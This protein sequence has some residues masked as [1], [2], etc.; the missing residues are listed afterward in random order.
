[1]AAIAALVAAPPTELLAANA[2]AVLLDPLLAAVPDLRAQIA[3][4]DAI[5]GAI[6]ALP[7][8]GAVVGSL[9][10]LVTMWDL[11]PAT[12]RAQPI[13]D[14]LQ[15]LQ[16]LVDRLLAVVQQSQE[17]VQN[18]VTEATSQLARVREQ[19]VGGFQMSRIACFQPCTATTNGTLTRRVH[20]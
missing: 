4:M 10:L 18:V 2:A 8:R 14:V 16:G 11:L 3:L 15:A 1:M 7:P 19:G 17:T 5:V 12:N 9:D 20:S 13:D 6:D